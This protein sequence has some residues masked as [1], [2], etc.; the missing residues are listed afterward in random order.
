MEYTDPAR[1]IIR[2]DATVEYLM[3]Q[4]G[5]LTPA[6]V[7]HRHLVDGVVMTENLYTYEP[8]KLFSTSSAI[9][10]GEVP[11]TPPPPEPIKK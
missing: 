4:H 3:S 9:K 5:F 1:K 11:D 8:F 7:L 2:D 10:F 6:S